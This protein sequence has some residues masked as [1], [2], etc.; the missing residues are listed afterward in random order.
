MTIMDC[1]EIIAGFIAGGIT[2][3]II[4]YKILTKGMKDD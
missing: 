2:A 1:I 4:L 3:I